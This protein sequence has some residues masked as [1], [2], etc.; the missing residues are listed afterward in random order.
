METF[1]YLKS[2]LTGDASR[3]V[4][5]L[6]VTT[7]NYEKALQDLVTRCSNVQITVNSHFEKLTKLPVV[8]NN[9]DTAKLRELYDKIETNLRSLRVIGIQA[10]T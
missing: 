3:V 2:F 10:G 1:T 9:E 8:H 5:D 6:A 7:E 4:K